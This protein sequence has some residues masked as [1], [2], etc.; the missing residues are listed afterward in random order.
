MGVLASSGIASGLAAGGVERPCEHGRR[1]RRTPVL[2]LVAPRGLLRGIGAAPAGAAR[3]GPIALIVVAL[4]VIGFCAFLGEGAAADWSGVYLHEDAGSSAG[5]A[6]FAFTAFAIGMV[7]GRFC[8]DAL[9]ARF[10]PV[11]V[12]RAGGV[13]ASLAL[14]SASPSSRCRWF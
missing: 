2:G 7:L 13:L 8:G 12:V 1:G 6:A 14:T 4:G 5:L 10:G 11:T 9:S 3:R